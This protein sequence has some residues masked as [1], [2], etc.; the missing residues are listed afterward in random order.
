MPLN[1]QHI[2][3]S[4]CHRSDLFPGGIVLSKAQVEGDLLETLLKTG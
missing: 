3:H 2:V 4:L 1:P